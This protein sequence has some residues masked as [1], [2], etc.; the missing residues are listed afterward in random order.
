M[1]IPHT[2]WAAG[3]CAQLRLLAACDR[4]LASSVSSVPSSGTSDAGFPAS[5]LATSTYDTASHVAAA[6]VAI[7]AAAHTVAASTAALT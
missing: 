2:D 3:C 5:S 6:A 7:A 4:T 1:L